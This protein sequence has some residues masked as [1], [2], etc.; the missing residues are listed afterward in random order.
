MFIGETVAV[1]YASALFWAV[2][3]AAPP[4]KKNV[5]YASWNLVWTTIAATIASFFLYSILSTPYFLL[6]L[7]IVHALLFIPLLESPNSRASSI[8]IAR[9]YEI[10]GILS[11]LLHIGNTILLFQR[12]GIQFLFRVIGEKSAM[13]SVGW[14]VIFCAV[15]ALLGT[16]RIK[17][18]TLPVA[19]SL[20]GTM[21][22][23]LSIFPLEDSGKDIN[24]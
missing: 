17:S 14:D 23:I 2:R 21:G 19:I 24:N 3:E 8:S 1:S 9:L 4:R 18:F 7:L 10:N 5:E 6:L 11:A 16:N 20:G 15:I 12:G 22:G 13:S